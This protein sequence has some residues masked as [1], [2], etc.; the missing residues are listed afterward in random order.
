[1]TKKILT[2]I[3]KTPAAPTA[4]G[5]VENETNLYTSPDSQLNINTIKQQRQS[6]CIANLLLV[7]QENALSAKHLVS[8]TGMS[9]RAVRKQ[10][11]VERR[12]GIPILADNQTGYYL[13]AN[14]DEQERFINSM[15][16]RAGEILKSAAAIEKGGCTDE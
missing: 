16:H 10:I 11:E 5:L 13:P 9:N 7:G 3:K 4:G 2:A 1:M 8:I 15:R 6:F 14:E 12:Q